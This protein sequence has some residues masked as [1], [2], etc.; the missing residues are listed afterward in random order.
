MSTLVVVGAQW[1]DEGKGKVVDVV[2]ARADLVARFAGGNNAGHTLVVDGKQIITHLVPSGCRY[3]GTRCVLGAGMV[4]DPDVF[5]TEVGELRSHGLLMDD[6]LRVSTNAHVIWPFHRTLDALREDRAK[7]R[8][9]QIGTTRRGVGPAY[10]AKAARRGIRIRDLF[11]PDRLRGLLERCK[12]VFDRE[13]AAQD[14]GERIDVD[15]MLER[16][17]HWAEW[18]EPM[19]C[20]AGALCREAIAARRSVL[21]EGAQGAM[22]DVDHGTYPFVTSSNAI[23]GGVCTGIGVGPTC[24]DDV[25]GIT[26]AYTTRVGAGPFPTRLVDAMGDRLRDAGREYGATTGRPR[27]CGWLDLPALAYASAVNGMTGLCVTKLDVLADL[28]HAEVCVAYEDGVVPGL[29]DL[30]EARPRFRVLD[31]W[32]DPQ[33]GGRLRSARTLEE[34]PSCVRAYL[35][36]IAEFVGVPIVLASVGPDREQTIMLRRPFESSTDRD[37]GS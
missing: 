29:H 1:G 15:A 2:A 33:L 35:D 21:F 3:P 11:E 6:E 9:G 18:I 10:E 32:D 37:H 13:L 7:A 30:A 14:L 23:A 24:I 19:A 8:A 5:E 34:I 27:D 16:A 26:K 25:W 4:I 28:R 17:K 31:G 20:D 36:L 22:L 12:E